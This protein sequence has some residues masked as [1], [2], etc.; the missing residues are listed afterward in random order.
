M[1]WE[2]EFNY[3]AINNFGAQFAKGE[4]FLFLNND[5]E[6]IS[7]DLFEEMLGYAQRPEVGI[8]GVRLL[9]QDNTIQ[10]AG[11]SSDL[12]ESRGHT[13]IG[14]HEAESSYFHRA[15]CA[16]D[17]S[18]VTAACMMTRASCFV[19]LVDLPRSLRSH[20]TTSITV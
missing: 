4:Y 6:I 17:Y 11:L 7:K 18:A 9:Y 8:V 3:S 14:L 12:A 10:H 15:M 5:T 1:K 19:S 2:R 13:F 16:Q 20:L